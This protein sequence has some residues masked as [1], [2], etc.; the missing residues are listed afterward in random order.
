MN[1]R[2]EIVQ[3]SDGSP[4]LLCARDQGAAE[5]M[6]HSGG[7]LSE[8]LFIYHE[9]LKETRSR[10]WPLLVLSLGLGLGYN[11]WIALAEVM[12]SATFTLWSFEADPV[13]RQSFTMW[14]N[15]E[16]ADTTLAEAFTA[17]LESVAAHFQIKSLDLKT[18]GRT[19]FQRGQWHIRGRFPDDAAGT[20]GCTCVFYD[21]FS[22]KMDPD[23]WN[24][25][26]LVTRLAQVSDA[27][28]VLATYAATGSLNR[29]LKRLGFRLTGK[30]GFLNKRESTLAIREDIR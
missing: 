24:E 12:D 14:L 21:A 20:E 5:H 28:C 23:L 13:L 29:A 16:A 26:D 6:H 9:A 4:T 19:A 15:G 22:K 7:A 27:N 2:Y 11:E 25:D 10:G 18:F 17:V 30:S 8:S 1:S 3:T